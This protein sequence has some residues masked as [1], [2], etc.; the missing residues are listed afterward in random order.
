MPS[1]F[2][3]IDSLVNVTPNSILTFN[4]TLKTQTITKMQVENITDD[5]LCYKMKTTDTKR[6][7]VRPNAAVLQ[8]HSSLTIVI[9]QKAFPDLTPDC[10][11]CTDL[12]QLLV[13]RLKDV[14]SYHPILGEEPPI[15]TDQS[16]YPLGYPSLMKLWEFAPPTF[17]AK[18]KF[19]VIIQLAEPSNQEQ[20]TEHTQSADN[21]LEQ[22]GQPVRKLDTAPLPSSEGQHTQVTSVGVT[23]AASLQTSNNVSKQISDNVSTPTTMLKSIENASRT[24]SSIT[25][26]QVRTANDS[27]RSALKEPTPMNEITP[28]TRI[29]TMKKPASVTPTKK[30]NGVTDKTPSSPGIDYRS[31]DFAKERAVQMRT[32]PKIVPPEIDIAMRQRVAVERAGELVKVINCRQKEIDVVRKDLLEARHKLSDA[33]VATQPAYDV[34]YEINESARVPL[35]QICIMAIISGALLQLLV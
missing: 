1:S 26:S 14:P 32:A 25:S 15:S 34:R 18:K 29:S 3:N 4:I 7:S 5:E 33:K 16:T 2:V 30:K 28:S 17:V 6:Y 31:V 22:Q 8:P 24:D 9:T 10:N 20:P 12:F 27:T 19:S 23:S 13:I 11:P 21:I 35:M